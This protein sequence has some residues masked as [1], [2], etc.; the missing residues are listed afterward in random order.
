SLHQHHCPDTLPESTQCASLSLS[1]S[2]RLWPS[3]IPSASAMMSTP[4]HYLTLESSPTLPISPLST[5]VPLLVTLTTAVQ[6]V[7]RVCSVATPKS[8]TFHAT[9]GP[10]TLSRRQS[11]VTT[12]TETVFASSTPTPTLHA[13]TDLPTRSD[14]RLRMSRINVFGLTPVALRSKLRY[15][16]RI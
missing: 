14:L 6:H 16:G 15:G 2:S 7:V 5:M 12:S 1:L 10:A 11:I 4:A 3:A 8:S 13:R 9:C